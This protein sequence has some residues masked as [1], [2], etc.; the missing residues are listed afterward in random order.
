MGRWEPSSVNRKV[1]RPSAFP[2]HLG[3]PLVPRGT[4]NNDLELGSLAPSSSALRQAG[5]EERKPLKRC[6]SEA[7]FRDQ[8]SPVGEQLWNPMGTM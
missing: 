6:C 7:G 2:V 8:G 1:L 5:G 3:S 4:F